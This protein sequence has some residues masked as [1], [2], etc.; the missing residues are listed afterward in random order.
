MKNDEKINIEQFFDI[1]IKNRK[2]NEIE[3][4]KEEDNISDK[5]KNDKILNFQDD[6]DSS[7]LI[8]ENMK[9]NEDIK[10]DEI[11]NNK[12]DENCK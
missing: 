3:E 10:K 7:E 8:S 9:T 11:N 2:L 4:D 6:D 12:N 1:L 5:N